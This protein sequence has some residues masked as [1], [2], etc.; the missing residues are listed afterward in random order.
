MTSI[1]K[2]D[3]I[4]DNIY[5][6]LI[7]FE[8]SEYENFANQQKEQYMTFNSYETLKYK[9][10]KNIE[11]IKLTDKQKIN[12]N[13]QYNLEQRNRYN[14]FE[15]LIYN[16][17]IRYEEQRYESLMRYDENKN[18]RLRSYQ[19]NL[20]NKD[21]KSDSSLNYVLPYYIESEDDKL[22]QQVYVLL[23]KKLEKYLIP[24]I[25]SFEFKEM[26]H[27]IS[28]KVIKSNNNDY[29]CKYFK[30]DN[31]NSK[32]FEI[33]DYKWFKFSEAKN[34]IQSYNSINFYNLLLKELKSII[35]PEYLQHL[36]CIITF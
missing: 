30:V 4:E 1:D 31:E 29:L 19:E 16:Q 34:I 9:R 27:N 15:D 17:Y 28:L 18:E 26:N 20:N 8:S 7:D 22:E 24:S 10:F 11:N 21:K 25:I 32:S 14:R 36:E 12:R 23:E 35:I 6:N 13:V 2:F 3:S 33:N 5:K